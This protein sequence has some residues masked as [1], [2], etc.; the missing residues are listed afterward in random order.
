MPTPSDWVAIVFSIGQLLWRMKALGMLRGLSHTEFIVGR[1]DGRVYF[2]ETSARVGGAHIADLVEAATR[3]HTWL[4]LDPDSRLVQWLY[5]KVDTITTGSIKVVASV[6]VVYGL[7]LCMEGYGLLMRR[8]WAE[9][10]V[11]VATCLPIPVELYELVEHPGLGK[12]FIIG[13]NLFI[14]GYLYR[15][16]QAFLTRAQRRALKAA[17]VHAQ[18][19]AQGGASSAPPPALL[20]TP[21]TQAARS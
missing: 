11:I 16:R 14:V 8:K 21:C 2:L 13:L 17:K 12:V 7:L 20:P 1:E 9:V 6:E 19:P 18:A 3:L 10:L 5:D 4:H 15:R